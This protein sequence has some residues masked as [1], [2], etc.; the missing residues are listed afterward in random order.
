VAGHRLPHPLLHAAELI[1]PHPTVG[2]PLHLFCPPPPLLL[3]IV[4]RLQRV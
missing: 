3:T 4:A 1:L 2:R